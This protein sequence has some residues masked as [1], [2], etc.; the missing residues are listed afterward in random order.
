MHLQYSDNTYCVCVDFQI[1]TTTQK[2]PETSHVS[3]SSVT[4]LSS[5]HIAGLTLGVILLLHLIFI[6]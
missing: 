3:T 5:P 6:V 1:A 4:H 2:H